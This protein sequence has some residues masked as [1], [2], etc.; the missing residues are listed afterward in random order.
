MHTPAFGHGMNGFRRFWIPPEWVKSGEWTECPCGWGGHLKWT[1]H[2]ARK[3]HVRSWER[4]IKRCG[5][6]EAAYRDIRKELRK[7]GALP[8]WLNEEARP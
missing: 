1:K 6:L 7:V 8:E 5:S 2:Y 3:D 4:R